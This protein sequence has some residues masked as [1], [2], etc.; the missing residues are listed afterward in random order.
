MS[1]KKKEHLMA[2]E[3]YE[4]RNKGIRD[5]ADD[6]NGWAIYY[7]KRGKMRNDFKSS[8]GCLIFAISFIL[9]LLHLL[10]NN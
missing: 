7:R 4:N 5:F 10:M 9:M 8:W 1:K 2:T 3:E 6:Y